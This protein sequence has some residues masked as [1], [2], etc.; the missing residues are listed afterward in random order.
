MH[1]A[2]NVNKAEVG[3][4]VRSVEGKWNVTV[5]AERPLCARVGLSTPSGH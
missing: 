5:I 2:T 1:F 3:R 4:R